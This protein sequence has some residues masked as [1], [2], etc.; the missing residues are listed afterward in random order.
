MVD[1]IVMAAGRCVDAELVRVSGGGPKSLILVKERPVVS[2]VVENLRSCELVSRVIL[3][4]DTETCD[5][6]GDVDVFV[7]AQDHEIE[8]VVRAVREAENAQRCLMIGGD[9]ALASTEA[10]TDLLAHAPESDVVYPIVERDEL[11][12]AFPD[13]QAFYVPAREGRYTGSSCLL[14]RPGVALSND[15]VISRLLQAR[16]DPKSLIGLVG[17]GNAV[18]FMV[19]TLS[20]REFERVLSDALGIDCS[21]FVSHYPE[22]FVS[23]ESI[24]DVDVI[25]RELSY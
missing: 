24:Q 12:E 6:A 13:K 11:E 21:V 25:E 19:S 10:L 3:V 5:A 7:D 16:E 17:L 9:M 18:K 4:S 20:L 8:T 23:I 22:L 2:V 1:A 14:F 15:Q